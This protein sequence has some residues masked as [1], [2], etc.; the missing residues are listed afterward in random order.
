MGTEKWIEY[1]SDNINQTTFKE[2]SAYPELLKIKVKWLKKNGDKSVCLLMVD[3]CVLIVQCMY[4][5]GLMHVSSWFDACV[6]MVSCMCPH[7]LMHVSS[8]L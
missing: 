4:P 5:H 8:P 3:A 2:L 6:L 7:D 1:M